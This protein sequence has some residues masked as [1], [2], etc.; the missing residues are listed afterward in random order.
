MKGINNFAFTSF[1]LRAIA[2]LRAISVPAIALTLSSTIATSGAL[3][4]EP[5]DLETGET[6]AFSV[7]LSDQNQKYVND[8]NNAVGDEDDYFVSQW[9]LSGIRATFRDYPGQQRNSAFQPQICG[10]MGR[11]TNQCTPT[12]QR[13][14]TSLSPVDYTP[15]TIYFSL[16]DRTYRYTNGPVSRD[17]ANALA[18]VTSDTIT[19]RVEFT[20]PGRDDLEV[21]ID[22]NTVATWKTVFTRPNWWADR[23]LEEN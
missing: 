23:E 20:E 11:G 13:E 14:R 9:S 8:R 18:N 19:I 2:T 10:F 16:G 17:L 4:V 21:E 5:V 12:L 1:V 3:A 22:A 7:V 15:S 6:E